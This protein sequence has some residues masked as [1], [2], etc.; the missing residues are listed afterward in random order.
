MDLVMIILACSLNQNYQDQTHTSQ[1]W[2]EEPQ[3]S[4]LLAGEH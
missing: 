4:D 3:V 2:A 1:L